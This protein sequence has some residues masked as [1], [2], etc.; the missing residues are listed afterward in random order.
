LKVLKGFI[1]KWNKEV[2]GEVEEKIKGLIVEIADVDA[3]CEE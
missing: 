2:Y 1:R 3:K